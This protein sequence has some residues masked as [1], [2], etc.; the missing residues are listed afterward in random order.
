MN[1]RI[2]LAAPA[3][4]L[5]LF[6]SAVAHAS[7]GPGIRVRPTGLTGPLVPGVPMVVDVTID[8]DHATTLRGFQLTAPRAPSG[9]GGGLVVSGVPDSLPLPANTPLTLHLTLTAPTE[10]ARITFR[11]DAD[12]HTWTEFFDLSRKHFDRMHRTNQSVLVPD[13]P[14][15]VLGPESDDDP[16]A[17]PEPAPSAFERP[18]R[19][20]RQA[21]ATNHVVRVHGRIA[22]ERRKS[23]SDSGVITLGAD[24]VRVRVYDQETG[25]DDLLYEGRTDANGYYDWN[26]SCSEAEPDLYV[27]VATIN[28]AVNVQDGTWNSVWSFESSVRV[29][30][31]GNDVNF[32]TLKPADDY[33]N[34]AVHIFNSATRA[35]RWWHNHSSIPVARQ[36]IEW[37]SG[38]WAHYDPFGGDLH[39]PSEIAGVENFKHARSEG[40]VSHEYGHA[41]MNE[42][43]GYTPPFDYDNGICNNDNGD[44]GHCRWCPEDG[45]TAVSEG[46]AN[47]LADMATVNYASLYGTS[48]YDPRDTESIAKCTD[49]GSP[50][51]ANAFVTEGNFGSLLRDLTDSDD[52]ADENGSDYAADALHLG[53]GPVLGAISSTHPNTPAQFITA[54][55][56][57]NPGLN[58]NNLW[59]TFANCRY[60]LADGVAPGNPV[61]VHS[62]DHTL[63]VA[64]PDATIALAWSAPSDDF[65]GVAYYYVFYGNTSSG[66][67]T[68]L[69]YTDY[70]TGST[71]SRFEQLTAFLPQRS[72]GNTYVKIQAVDRAGN[73]SAGAVSGPYVIRAALPADLACATPAGWT[74]CVVPRNTTGATSSNCALTTSLT[75]NGSTYLNFETSN[76]GESQATAFTQSRLHVDG[77]LVDSMSV[78]LLVGPTGWT[79]MLNR[80]P[81]TIRGGLH[82]LEVLPDAKESLEEPI[83][84]N[85]DK[86]VQ[87]NWTAANITFSGKVR[88]RAPP[89]AYAGWSGL[90]ILGL[91]YVNCDGLAYTVSAVTPPIAYTFAGVWGAAVD[92]AENVNLSLHAHSTSTSDGGFRARLAY[93]SRST[94]ELDAVFTNQRLVS[95]SAYDVGV[96]N[97]NGGT[98]DYL[99][100]M[101]A[102]PSTSLVTGDSVTIT[103]ADSI[104]MALRTLSLA[105]TSAQVVRVRVTAGTGPIYALWVSNTMTSGTLSTY[106]AKVATDTTGYAEL[107]VVPA[108]SGFHHLVFYRNPKDGWAGVTFT[109]KIAPLKPDVAPARPA[110]WAGSI[111]P[112][113]S[114]DASASFVPA[115]T[116]LPGDAGSTWLNTAMQDLSAGSTGIVNVFRMLD[117]GMIDNQL[118]AF[119]GI[120]TATS[121]NFGPFTFPA[122]RHM[123][124]VNADPTSLIAELVES[125]NRWGR[126]WVWAPPASALATPLWRKGTNGGPTSGWEWADTTTVPSYSADGIRTPVFSSGNTAGW[127]AVAVTP[128]PGSD[129][130]VQ[131]HDVATNASTGFDDPRAFSAWAGDATDLVLVN[132]GAT[133]YRAFDVG[134]LRAAEDTAS[135]SAE[136]AAATLRPSGVSGPFTLGAEHLVHLHAFDFAAGHHVIDVVNQTGSVD[137]G[138]AVYGGP[139]PYQN[140]SDG[141]DVAESWLAPAGGHEHL[142]FDVTTP[143]RDALAVYK[144]GAS[145]RSKSGT[146]ALAVDQA[147]L[148]TGEAPL[149]AKRMAASPSPFAA[150]TRL[151]WTLTE[152]A[153]AELA[154]YD[155]R[156]ARVRTLARGRWQAG[157]HSVEWTGDDD[158]GRPL[159]PGLYFVRFESRGRTDVTRVVLAR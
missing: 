23:K 102:A 61:N 95:A 147:W 141:E 29:D 109:V 88:R 118:Y 44:P 49:D 60:E 142:E 39:I 32:H 133:S 137:W 28:G 68:Q 130:D 112:R 87:Y 156:G 30:F 17:G 101:V 113:A 52:E 96:V 114:N 24:H 79:N 3:A 91:K 85:N 1:R 53:A 107:P 134:V 71:L 38:D 6:A 143:G 59:G 48:A 40:T 92:P 15:V 36:A 84:T 111:V 13:F 73:V 89:Q 124:G 99:A 122:G 55:R 16:G 158:A 155:V 80:G 135:Y 136:I 26:V 56:S 25:F 97:A 21:T 19:D 5:L 8:A 9:A 159:A 62:T 33:T 64:S 34:L 151:A 140:R 27:E 129:V 125:N 50:Y 120:G 150:R 10:D 57:Q 18:I 20:R 117:D 138:A 63:N 22:Y 45:G 157:E 37:P 46:F 106:D 121:V 153:D 154:V 41:V 100:A 83:E 14:D 67:W 2:T 145:E 43:L 105:N 149:V 77:V 139:R 42:G 72:P 103:L 81:Y 78:G 75:G 144:T 94:G 51:F 7:L 70:N 116:S 126:Q 98:H 146:Y 12:G 74:S 104:M 115:P 93:S 76:I 58:A 90:P 127:A 54:F 82:T 35:W 11:Y 69:T 131:L 128:R 123:L 108:A 65:S 148:G 152:T 86:S 119:S 110:G 66:P 132:F 31:T 4:C 47:Y